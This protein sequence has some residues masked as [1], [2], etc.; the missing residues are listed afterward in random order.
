MHVT[1]R[2]QQHR[3]GFERVSLATAPDR[4]LPGRPQAQREPVVHA[5]T[6]RSVLDERGAGKAGQA[7]GVI[8]GRRGH[9]PSY[10]TPRAW[11]H[12]PP[13]LRVAL[14]GQEAELVGKSA[15]R[16]LEREALGDALPWLE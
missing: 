15:A 6:G 3:A 7:R 14:T 10:A 8:R 13:K 11:F 2:Q 5:G 12:R 1:W 4:R 16:A 9:R